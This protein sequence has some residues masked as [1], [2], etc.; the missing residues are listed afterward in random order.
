MTNHILKRPFL[1]EPVPSSLE[2]LNYD[3]LQP[4]NGPLNGPL[5]GPC[6]AKYFIVIESILPRKEQ[7]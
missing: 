3:D 7:H 6:M 4:R 5:N 2:S 1:H